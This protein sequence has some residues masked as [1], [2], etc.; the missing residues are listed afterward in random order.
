MAAIDVIASDTAIY[1]NNNTAPAPSVVQQT[2]T[3]AH[4]KKFIL[5]FLKEILGEH[6]KGEKLRHPWHA[7]PSPRAREVNQRM[8]RYKSERR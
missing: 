2:P 5:P 7:L 8:G 6:S 4:R 1:I 3:R